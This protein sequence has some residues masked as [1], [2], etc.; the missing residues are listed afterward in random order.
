MSKKIFTAD[1]HLQSFDSDTVQLEDGISLKLNEL[2][3]SIK[4]MFDYAVKN[5][6]DTVIFGGD[7]SHKRKNVDVKPFHLFQEL[8]ISYSNKLNYIFIPGNHDGDGVFREYNAVSLFKTIPNTKV[9]NYPEVIG[10]ITFIP[11]AQDMMEDIKNAESN[12]ILISHF[13]LTEASTDSGLKVATKF[14][15]KDLKK[16][17]LV[18]LGDYHTR[19]TVDHIHYPGTL[20]PMNRGERGPKGFLV[21]DDETLKVD[22]IE[23]TGFRRYIDVELND[24]SDME[25][26]KKILQN[27]NETNDF[28]IIHNNLPEI[29]V[30]LKV[31]V[32]EE[33]IPIIDKYEPEEIIRGISSNMNLGEQMK[34]Y[35]ELNGI[36]EKEIDLYLN[37]GLEALRDETNNI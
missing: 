25:E 37:I 12:D 15:K 16:F 27:K 33:S 14:S 28:I 13:P 18:L 30:D 5:N 32:Q 1:L 8:L 21:F 35:L 22:F 34:K 24:D 26:I 17:K 11:D 7:I 4:Q 2:L 20:I 19:Q 29:P 23:V 9:F 36:S 6:I 31:M 3:N 10:N